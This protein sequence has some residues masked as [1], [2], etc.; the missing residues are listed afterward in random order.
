[1]T[2]KFRNYTSEPGFT[3]DFHCVRQFLVRLN[4]KNP[5]QYGFEWGRWEWGFSLDFQDTSNLSKIGLWEEDG[6]IIALAA[7]EDRLGSAYFCVSPGYQFLKAE[8]L[9]YASEHLRDSENKF[10]ALIY[11]SDREFQRIAAEQGF[12]PTQDTEPNAVLDIDVD[13]IAYVLPPGYALISLADGFDLFKF[14]SVL[15]K[16]FNHEGDPPSSKEDLESRRRNISGPHL[17]PALCILAVAPNGEYASYCGTWFDKDTEYALV[18]PVATHPDYRRLGLGRAVVLEAVKRCGNLGAKQ[19]YVGSAQ[20][21]YYQI[22]F[23]P[24]PAGTF[25]EQ[26]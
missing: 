3:D 1:M 6:E 15:W 9:Q 13:S 4:A 11:N 17:N 24:I 16:G 20:Q 5:I 18:E 14:H 23:H 19:A 2:I 25:W 10:K 8:M 21:F 22:G 12:K 26:R 7:Y